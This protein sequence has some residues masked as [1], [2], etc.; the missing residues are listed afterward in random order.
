MSENIY[1]G[2]CVR[3]NWTDRGGLRAKDG[4]DDT[5][6]RP[7]TN[8]MAGTSSTIQHIHTHT[9]TQPFSHSMWS[10]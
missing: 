9:H 7:N 1:E 8:K 10:Q 6:E 5:K 3:E 4:G 2:M